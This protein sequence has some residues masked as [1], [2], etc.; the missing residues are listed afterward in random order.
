MLIVLSEEPAIII[1]CWL[2]EDLRILL[3]P[4]IIISYCCGDLT[5]TIFAVY[6]SLAIPEGACYFILEEVNTAFIISL[7]I[8]DVTLALMVELELLILTSSF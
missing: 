5:S 3:D 1:C 2:L 6:S 4:A 8:G 7:C